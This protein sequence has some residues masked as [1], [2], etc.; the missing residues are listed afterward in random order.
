MRAGLVLILA[1]S[2]APL[3][4]QEMPALYDVT[5][6]AAD[7]VLNIRAAPDAIAPILGSLAPDARGIEVIALAG[8]WAQINTGEG[9]GHVA[10]RFLTPQPGPAWHA[11]ERP[12]SCF[13]TE[14]FWALDIDPAAGK[15]VLSS[16]ET[17]GVTFTLGLGYPGSAAFPV[18]GLPVA[19]GRM[20]LLAA[21]ACSDGMSD[22]AYGIGVS[23]H[24]PGSEEPVL[25]GCCSLA[26]P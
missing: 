24:P 16:P 17:D 12:L 25:T 26:A 20:L 22:R 3:A 1:L 5:G 19:G 10:L 23:F 4:A 11:L 2:S 18:A 15:A 13:R 9:V 21:R 6:V 14:P 8:G 7:D